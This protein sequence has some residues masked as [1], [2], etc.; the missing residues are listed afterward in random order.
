MAFHL[1][2]CDVDIESIIL[3]LYSIQ[4]QQQQQLQVIITK[5]K[6]D[7]FRFCRSCRF[8]F[9]SWCRLAGGVLLAVWLIINSKPQPQF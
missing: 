7:F 9:L 5:A 3:L 8:Y 4:D 1:I 6:K 2:L